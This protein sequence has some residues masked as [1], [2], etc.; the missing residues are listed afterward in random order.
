[1]NPVSV[2]MA[3]CT[4]TDAVSRP[5]PGVQEPGKQPGHWQERGALQHQL[6]PSQTR[7]EPQR[8]VLWSQERRLWRLT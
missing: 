2:Q 1:M 6:L 7:A 8:L 5:C 3:W 4:R